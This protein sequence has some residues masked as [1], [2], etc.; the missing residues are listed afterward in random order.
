MEGS[1]Q[2]GEGPRIFRIRLNTRQCCQGLHA[3]SGTASL[4]H[5][6][7]NS[8][9]ITI[10]R[11]LSQFLKLFLKGSLFIGWLILGSRTQSSS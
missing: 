1:A 4:R 10:P 11:R 6:I 9:N 7:E 2:S 3:D 8:V 5:N